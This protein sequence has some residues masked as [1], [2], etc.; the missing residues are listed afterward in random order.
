MY[1]D[2]ENREYTDITDGSLS[3]LIEEMKE[4]AEALPVIAQSEDQA[5]LKKL[6]D[7]LRKLEYRKVYKRGR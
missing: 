7:D 1:I 4:K 5:A 2:P 6:Q 3:D